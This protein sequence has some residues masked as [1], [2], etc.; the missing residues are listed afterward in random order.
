VID[1]FWGD[2][3]A[4]M[5]SATL[6][7]LI[8]VYV[9]I[10]YRSIFR[11]IMISTAVFVVVGLTVTYFRHSDY[12]VSYQYIT[13][14]IIALFFLM[15]LLIF[16][17]RIEKMVSKIST[18]KI[19]MKNNLNE[20][21]RINLIFSSILVCFIFANVWINKYRIFHKEETLGFVYQLYASLMIL[22]VV[23]EF[24]RV[25]AIRGKLLKEEWLPIVNTSGKEIGS[26]NYQISM[27]NDENKYIHPVVRII[28]L[29]DNRL[30]LQQH[31][32]R[33]ELY[34]AKWD[35]AVSGHLKFGEKIPECINRI[36]GE[37]Y[38]AEIHNPV[39]LGNYQ[40]E[41]PC[42]FQY[43]HLFLSCKLSQ[44]HPNQHMVERV[45]WWTIAQINENINSGI[46]T[47]NF[48]REFEILTRSGLIE[49]GRCKCECKLKDEFN[50]KN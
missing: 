26:V 37:A 45:K 22:A 34:S 28:V 25:F 8:S 6:A 29:D 46:F 11:W 13:G 15:I 19:S 50:I 31:K 14:E 38:G 2:F 41:N 40:I 20:L 16:R 4:W 23:Y 10:F 21:V 9:H 27:W 48:I 18:G 47:E 39:F 36:S 32:S 30:F 43:V 35:N 17:R 42:E 3:T 5:V 1:D 24:I 44:I 33:S 12:F 49:S 7:L